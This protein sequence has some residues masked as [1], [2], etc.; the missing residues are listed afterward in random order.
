[1]AGISAEFIDIPGT[2][3]TINPF[4]LDFDPLEH[5]LPE[6]HHPNIA[7]IPGS[8]DFLVRWYPFSKGEAAAADATKLEARLRRTEEHLASLASHGVGLPERSHFIGRNPAGGFGDVI[9]TVVERLEGRKLEPKLDR[10]HEPA[11][12]AA[13]AVL[14][15]C[16]DTLKNGD[17]DFPYELAYAHQYTV[18]PGVNPNRPNVVVH[19]IEARLESCPT[20][21]QRAILVHQS[22]DRLNR[23]APAIPLLDMAQANVRNE[24]SKITP[25]RASLLLK[26]SE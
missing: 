7:T 19:D 4:P 22:L 25:P 1:M 10:H 24:A 5:L 3:Q 18:T 23:W 11:A 9:L 6:A 2:G 13:R 20:D 15:L 17:P 12:R 8:D 14:G 26:V 21:A 16:R